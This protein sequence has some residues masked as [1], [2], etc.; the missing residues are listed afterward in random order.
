MDQFSRFASI[1]DL[2]SVIGYA[3]I[4][5]INTFGTRSMTFPE[6]SLLASAMLAL[7]WAA[8]RN[9]RERNAER[10]PNTRV[11]FWVAVALTSLI[12]VLR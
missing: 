4:T 5:T 11:V 12:F 9:V 8:C 7:F 3:M 1:D 2:W 10:N 6:I